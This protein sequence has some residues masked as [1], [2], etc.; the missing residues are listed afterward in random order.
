MA[1]NN[2][3]S[4]KKSPVSA[5]GLLKLKS[6]IKDKC[7]SGVYLFHGEEEYMKRF[8]FSEL[9][10]TAQGGEANI[11]VIEAENFSYEKLLDAAS[12]APAI[13]YTDSFF[14]DE[15]ESADTVALRV[16]KAEEAPVFKFTDS[17]KKAF[18]ELCKN[19][20]GEVCIVFYYPFNQ[21][22]ESEYAKSMKVLDGCG[23][24]NV[25]FFHESPTS[26]Q[27]KK[28]VKRHFDVK[29]C[30]VDAPTV[31]YFIE[32]VGVDMCTLL[33]EIEKLCAYA[34]QKALPAVY[35]EDIDF[36]CIKATEAK[37]DDVSRGV[38]DGDYPRAAAALAR[39]KAE[40]LSET[41]I[42]GAVSN[43]INELYT[44]DYYQNLG[45]SVQEICSKTGMRDFVVKNDIRA[46]SSL[47]SRKRNP[48][49]VSL[50]AAMK[51][52]NEKNTEKKAVSNPC[53]RLVAILA[54][55]DVKIKSFPSNKYI[56]LENMIFRMCRI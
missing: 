24:L 28:W 46:L 40:K 47:Y 27:L 2:F 34:S 4:K 45:M 5:D 22:K 42:F 31:D 39:L 32:T 55:Y 35:N 30:V 6:R 14:D 29:K 1:Y 53:E 25:G 36:I 51:M 10:K 20:P 37:L 18:E 12:A 21:K 48:G 38:I 33:S 8:Y 52:G 50:S 26:P 11:T 7:P 49:S 19:L 41:Y 17:E 16:I 3:Y 9:C 56:L 23:V 13:D 43:K 44:V 15:A 54:E